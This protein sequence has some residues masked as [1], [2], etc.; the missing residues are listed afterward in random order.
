MA[1]TS[2]LVC[3]RADVWSAIPIEPNTS[4]SCHTG[5]ASGS[6]SAWAR[7]P[8]P[9]AIHP[10]IWGQHGGTATAVYPP[11][12]V[13]PIDVEVRR[14]RPEELVGWLETVT[15]A[16]LTPSD[17]RRI[18]ELSRARFDPTRIWAAFDGR[19]VGTLRSWPT[20]LTV[21]GGAL[22]PAAAVAGVTVLPSHR[23]RGI[24][25]RLIAAEHEAASERG[26]AI[27][28]LH[29]SESSIYGRFGYGI[30]LPECEFV[31]DAQSTGFVAAAA[32]GGV[33]L[34]PLDGSTVELVR[35]LYERFRRGK[36]GEI[37]RRDDSFE[38]G[39]GLVETG[40][41][42]P[43]KGWVAVHRDSDGTVDGFVS[44][45]AEL[46]WERGQPR[47]VVAVRDL[48][49]VSDAAYDALWRYL[50]EIDLVATIRAER[51]SPYE[52]L[53]WILANR[54]ALEI[55][56]LGD[57]LWV[58]LL[59]VPAALS[60]RTY[61]RSDDLVIEVIGGEPGTDRTRVRLEAGPDGARCAATTSS[62]DLSIHADALGAAFLG[63]TPLRSAVL[64]RGWDEHRAGALTRADALLRTLDAPHCQTFF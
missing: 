7:R 32:A 12:M 38:T 49:A 42:A 13:S 45:G 29:A 54:R 60:A 26:E 52:R 8:R 1:A 14:I 9:A 19:V 3:A 59:D 62:A 15:T 50:A 55:G 64:A 43:W 31:L 39:L 41:D 34:A 20:E 46:K 53:P 24:L 2:S 22:V 23:R 6:V 28:I 17:T 18:A 40:W 44:Y 10:V 16:F 51:R 33:S 61:E 47:S 27:A 48:V 21:P 4:R 37:R 58:C 35:G 25:R 57:G 11:A 30:S 5:G 36:V 56:G 63:G